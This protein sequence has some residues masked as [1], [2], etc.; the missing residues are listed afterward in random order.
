[1]SWA[2]A[3]LSR[4]ARARLVLFTLLLLGLICRLIRISQPFVDQWSWREADVA[5]IAGNFF[6][7]G[8]NI[9]Y[10]QI[11]WGGPAPGYVGTEFPLVPFL[12]A[13]LYRLFGVQAWIGRGISLA[14][15][16]LSLPLFYGLVRR[17]SNPRSALAATGVYVLTPL[18]IFA[19]RSF[20]PDMASLSLAIAALALF[21][22][23][24]EHEPN[25]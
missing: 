1:M 17:L 6:R 14:F 25:G 18:G 15:F 16:A 2:A 21:A 4:P 24:L 19:S 10:P 3:A 8:F 7:H 20:M 22:A 12:A 5:M 9:F 11:D 13:L 23:W